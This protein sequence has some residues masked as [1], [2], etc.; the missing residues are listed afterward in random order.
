MTERRRAVVLCRPDTPGREIGHLAVQY[1]LDVVYTVFVETES[2]KLTAL[3]AGQHLAEHD[4]VVLV[5]PHLT[6]ARIRHQQCW[7]AVLA[8]ADVIAPDGSIDYPSTDRTRQGTFRI[9]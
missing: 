3:I 1:G 5:I 6:V 7:C 4:A 2:P 9:P 8:A